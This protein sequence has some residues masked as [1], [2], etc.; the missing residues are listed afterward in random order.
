MT[1]N[2]SRRRLSKRSNE[3]LESIG[4]RIYHATR[5]RINIDVRGEF[6]GRGA[7]DPAEDCPRGIAVAGHQEGSNYKVSLPAVI[8]RYESKDLYTARAPS[9][10]SVS[11]SPRSR[12]LFAFRSPSRAPDDTRFSPLNARNQKNCQQ[13]LSASPI[14]DNSPSRSAGPIETYSL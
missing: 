1:I 4:W 12:P 2:P 7:T 8:N 3:G 14:N 6:A 11:R 5:Q 9:P 10:C 13:L